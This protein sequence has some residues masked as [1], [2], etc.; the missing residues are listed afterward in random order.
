MAGEGLQDRINRLNLEGK[1]E[2]QADPA[3]SQE[4][5]EQLAD[6]GPVHA[7]EHWQAFYARVREITEGLR[8]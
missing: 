3:G 5:S 6:P 8:R 4:E 1:R 7:S 2:G